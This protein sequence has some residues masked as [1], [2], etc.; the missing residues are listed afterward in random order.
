MTFLSKLGKVMQITGKVLA[1]VTGFGPALAAL[2]PSKKD[3]EVLAKLVDPLTQIAGIVIQVEGMAQ[4][5]DTPL[6]GTQKLQMAT[7]IVAQIIVQSSILANHEIDNPV[8]FKQ[9]CASIASGMA[10]VLNSIK[11]DSAKTVTYSG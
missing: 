3:D 10:D 6:P 2:T 8:L 5:L 11:E 7:P 9:G 4:A 1:V